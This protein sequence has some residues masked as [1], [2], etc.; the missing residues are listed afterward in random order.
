MDDGVDGVHGVHG[1]HGVDDAVHVDVTHCYA[2]N[3]VLP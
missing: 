2:T 3:L 1:V